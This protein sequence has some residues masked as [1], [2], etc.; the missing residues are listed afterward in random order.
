[1]HGY[2]VPAM[3]SRSPDS[4]N[5]QGTLKHR[6]RSPSQYPKVPALV[7]PHGTPVEIGPN[8]IVSLGGSKMMKIRVFFVTSTLTGLKSVGVSPSSL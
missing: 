2:V 8:R 6:T 3:K 5:G 4:G 7:L 1:M